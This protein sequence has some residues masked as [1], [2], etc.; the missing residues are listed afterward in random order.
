MA[1]SYTQ[2]RTRLWL[3]SPAWEGADQCPGLTWLFINDSNQ[4][5]MHPT[6]FP[7]QL[8]TDLVLLMSKSADWDYYLGTVGKNIVCQDLS[9]DCCKPLVPSPSQSDSQW[10]SPQT[11]FPAISVGWDWS[12]DSQ[13]MTHSARE[14]GCLLQALFSHWRIWR[15]GG[16]LSLLCSADLGKSNAVCNHSSYPSNVVGLGL[17]GAGSASTS[18]SCSKVFSVVSCPWIVVSSCEEEWGQE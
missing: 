4:A 14:A 6:T 2:Q 8:H 12:E 10:S 17:C 7:G 5:D 16:D 3:S 9:A 11:D 13:E 18:P 15:L 1:S